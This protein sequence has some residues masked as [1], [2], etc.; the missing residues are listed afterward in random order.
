MAGSLGI[1]TAVGASVVTLVCERTEECSH[2]VYKVVPDGKCGSVNK[3]PDRWPV[4]SDNIVLTY[5]FCHKM[6]VNYVA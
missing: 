2:I 4:N 1:N 3:W 5:L 6:Y